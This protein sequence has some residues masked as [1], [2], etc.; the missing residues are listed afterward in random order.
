MKACLIFRKKDPIFF[1]IEKVFETVYPF[2]KKQAEVVDIQLPFYSNGFSSIFKNILFARKQ[3]ADIYHVTGDV[4]YTVFGLPRKETLLTIHD[5]VF[6]NHPNRIKR[7]ILQYLLL[8]WPVKFSAIVTTISEKSRQD[9]IRYTGCSPDK[10]A[11]IPNP[12][13]PA[14]SYTGKEFNKTR[15]VILFIGSTPNKNLKRVIEA[16]KDINCI[17]DIVGNI[18][19]DLQKLLKE[20]GVQYR[21]SVGLSNEKL[22]KKYIDSDL[23]LF[24][25]TYEGFGLPI[26]EAQQT[27]RPVITSNFS[28]MKEVA[29]AGAC[30]V[31]PYNVE[32]IRRGI[33]QVIEDHDYRNELVQKGKENVQQYQAEKIAQQ[34]LN[35]YQRIRAVTS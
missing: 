35:M 17:L 34:Y 27:G 25:S 13:D 6:M 18:P 21:Q 10:V 20:Q 29:G 30:L 16:V 23:V 22:V 24:P 11:V 8:K 33:L 12:I 32:A 7:M 28:P 3:Q 19:E 26:I 2:L 1:S 5:C 14:F 15:P 9:I 31:D 4:H